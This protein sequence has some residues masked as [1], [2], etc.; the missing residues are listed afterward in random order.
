M[1]RKQREEGGRIQSKKKG[2]ERGKKEVMA[3]QMAKSLIAAH[4]EHVHYKKSVPQ[5]IN[6]P[7]A[8]VLLSADQEFCF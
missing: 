3:R 4:Y 5:R 6:Q 1:A 8:V 2:R 7:L